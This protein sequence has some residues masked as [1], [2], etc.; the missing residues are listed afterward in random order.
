[1]SSANKVGTSP[2]LPTGARITRSWRA[3]S[4]AHAGP[5]VARSALTAHRRPTSAASSCPWGGPSALFFADEETFVRGAR[6]RFSV[7]PAPSAARR[8]SSDARNSLSCSQS[9]SWSGMK[10]TPWAFISSRN[11]HKLRPAAC[12]HHCALASRSWYVR[13]AA[14]SDIIGSASAGPV[15]ITDS[16]STGARTSRRCRTSSPARP[17]RASAAS[18]S[19][20]R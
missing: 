8:A 7:G 11:S 12:A 5:A 13:R 14:L 3:W 2:T 18:S 4:P 10:G 19:G 17:R 15:T 16:L 9:E 1:M 20:P 6:R